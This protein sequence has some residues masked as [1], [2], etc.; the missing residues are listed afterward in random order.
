MDNI[1]QP[2]PKRRE[3]PLFIQLE[4]CLNQPVELVERVKTL[5]NVGGSNLVYVGASKVALR[6]VNEK[7]N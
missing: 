7:F 4:P 5:K 3:T 2:T 1:L 6:L